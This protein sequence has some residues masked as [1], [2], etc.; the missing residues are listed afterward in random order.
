[1]Q[2]QQTEDVGLGGTIPT[3][4][5]GLASALVGLNIWI[6]ALNAVAAIETVPFQ[7]VTGQLS[8]E[9]RPMGFTMGQ[10]TRRCSRFQSISDPVTRGFWR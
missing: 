6:P 5:L 10:I 4:G 2:L 1:V 7:Q 9:Q 3:I 8:A